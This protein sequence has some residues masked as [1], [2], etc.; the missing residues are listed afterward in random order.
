M[1]SVFDVMSLAFGSARV[2]GFGRERKREEGVS[3]YVRDC[4]MSGMNMPFVFLAYL[5]PLN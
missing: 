1:D 2:D 5:V 3:L 4:M